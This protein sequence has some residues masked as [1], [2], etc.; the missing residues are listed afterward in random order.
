VAVVDGQDNRVPEPSISDFVVMTPINRLRLETNVDTFVD[1]SFIGSISGA[2]LTV[3][4]V[5]IGSLTIN[6]LVFGPNVALNTLIV[7]QTSG[8]PLGVGTYTLSQTQNLGSQKMACGVVQ[9]LQPTQLTVQL[10][11]HGPN[12]ADN[13]QIITTTFRDDFAVEALTALN[14]NVAPLYADDPKQIP[15]IND[16]QQYETRWIIEAVLQVNQ[17]VTA[18]QQFADQVQVGLDLVD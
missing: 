12:S 18:P 17:T 1:C 3:T 11:V 4:Q 14:T 10:D 5:L 7:A 16:Q 15:F 8:T 2:V 6:N 9:M 13:A